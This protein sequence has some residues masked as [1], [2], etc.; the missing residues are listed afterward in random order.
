MSQEWDASGL[1]DL[2]D[3]PVVIAD[4]FEGDGCAFRERMEKLLDG[5]RLVVDPG[6]LNR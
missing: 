4:G 6:S 3:D 2:V 1:L 5:A